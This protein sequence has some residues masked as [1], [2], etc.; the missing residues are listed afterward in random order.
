MDLPFQI[1]VARAYFFRQRVTVAWRT[2]LD[3]IGD[4][5]IRPLQPRLRQQFVQELAC[6]PD[7]RTPLFVLIEAGAFADEHD[8]ALGGPSPGTAFLRE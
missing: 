4:P 8:L 3:H 6:G 2:A 1:L 7:E 5:H